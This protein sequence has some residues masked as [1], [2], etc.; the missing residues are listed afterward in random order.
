[1][2]TEFGI[3]IAIVWIWIPLAQ[4]Q[5]SVHPDVVVIVDTSTSM[6]RAGMDPERSSLLVTKL[7]ADIAPGDLAVIRLL[8]LAADRALVPSRP[9]DENVACAEDTS[10]DC[11]RVEPTADWHADA[12]T[13]RYGALVRA[14]R[15]DPDYKRTL[16]AH[17]QQRSNNSLF[18]L[19]FQV[20]L[21]VFDQH[22]N[23]KPRIVVWLSDGS[24]E[25][26]ELLYYATTEVKAAQA[27]IH[28][29]VFG[30]GSLDLPRKI[31]VEALQVHDPAEMM[32]AFAN[33]FRRIVRAPYRID[34]LLSATPN[35]E[36]KPN[37]EEAWIVVYGDDTLADVELDSASG[38]LRADYAADSWPSAGAYKVAHVTQPAAGAWTV[39][40]Q[41]GGP[42]AAY[43]VIQRSD[44]IPVLVSPNQALAGAETALI[45]EIRAGLN[46]EVVRDPE[47]LHDAVVSAQ[48]EGETIALFDRGS[49]GDSVAGDLRFSGLK[50]FPK[51]GAIPV[52]LSLRSEF[53]DQDNQAIVEVAGQFKYAG[54]PLDVDLGILG[55]KAESCRPLIFQADQRGD[56][57]FELKSLRSPPSGHVLE[58]RTPAGVLA[59]DA[60]ALP[61]NPSDSLRICLKTSTRV[62]S[63]QA[64][65]EPWLAFQV[66][67]SQKPEHRIV[68]QLR[69]QV[70]GLSFWAMWGWLF[71]SILA[72][73]LTLFISLG[74]FL[75]KRFR[76][77]FAV[78]FTPERD[79]L[80]LQSAQPVKQ[81]RG[82]GSGFCRNARA[83][84]HAD[85]RLNGKA[86]GALAGLFAESGGVWVRAGSGFRLFRETLQGDWEELSASG[87]RCRSGDI[88][89]IGATG[90]YFRIAVR[91]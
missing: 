13:H 31:G 78:A 81:W 7:L 12:R 6:R 39:R 28:A 58:V 4:A 26:E 65:G 63:S 73:L 9:L 64:E 56:I 76:G 5:D 83:Y 2:R 24:S 79:E 41:G 16:D 1:M 18:S 3:W 30:A 49:A 44:L 15:G 46:G 66:Q 68:L 77:A 38:A 86:R 53:A 36:M 47:I 85:Y 54:G 35:F 57:L 84:L 55:A 40:A 32:K 61:I 87:C 52:Q 67:G 74:F 23:T 11:R 20:A 29:I 17:L 25:Q 69:W 88:F 21:G 75:P 72:V 34:K 80:D 60:E 89:R 43:A 22:P 37:V 50:T 90:P 82:V 27:D 70:R 71:Y 19:A 42:Q 8:D 14:Q 10:Q 91:G 33:V 48:I 51:A 45:V 62:S 59:V